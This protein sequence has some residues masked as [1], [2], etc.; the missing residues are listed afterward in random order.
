MRLLPADK[1]VHLESLVFWGR[2]YITIIMLKKYT[3]NP[4]LSHDEQLA[5]NIIIIIGDMIRW[6]NFRRIAQN[7]CNENI[8]SYSQ[9]S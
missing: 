1:L 6:F 2:I 7:F 4:V 9:S 3:E 8:R 5:D